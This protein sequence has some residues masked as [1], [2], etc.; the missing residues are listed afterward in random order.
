MEQT[1]DLGG[2]REECVPGSENRKV[3]APGVDDGHFTPELRHGA[4]DF[5]LACEEL[6]EHDGELDVFFDVLRPAE[7]DVEV[8]DVTAQDSP[9]RKAGSAGG[10]HFTGCGLVQVVLRGGVAGER[11]G[12]AR[13]GQWPRV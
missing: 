8:V 9:S 2:E 12:I 13:G 5:Q 10:K 4:E 7:A 6:L 11:N 1:L 3:V